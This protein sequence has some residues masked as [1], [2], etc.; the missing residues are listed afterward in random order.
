MFSKRPRVI[1]IPETPRRVSD[2]HFRAKI[3]KFGHFGDN[4]SRQLRRRAC[5]TI[6]SH[7][8]S[9]S[10]SWSF[11]PKNAPCYNVFRACPR[12]ESPR[13]FAPSTMTTFFLKKRSQQT[14]LTHFCKLRPRTCQIN[15]AH[16]WGCVFLFWRTFFRKKWWFFWRDSLLLREISPFFT[17]IFIKK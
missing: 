9:Q 4:R 6:L 7:F 1:G 2:D 13:K 11:S 15:L 16:F 5:K 8:L 3:R 17:K 10:L 14:N 12:N